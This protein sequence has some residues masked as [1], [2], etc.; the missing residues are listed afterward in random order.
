MSLCVIFFAFTWG[1]VVSPNLESIQIFLM[2]P[3]LIEI[4]DI[5]FGKTQYLTL[6]SNNTGYLSKIKVKTCKFG[7]KHQNYG[8]SQNVQRVFIEQ[9]CFLFF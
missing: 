5:F 6:P 1:G 8:E 9:K 7:D 3:S 4:K 2:N